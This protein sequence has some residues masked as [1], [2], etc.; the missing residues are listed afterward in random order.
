ME[1][2]TQTIAPSQPKTI[3]QLVLEQL[4]ALQV[5][6]AVILDDAFSPDININQ[7]TS[8]V[9]LLRTTETELFARVENVV[10]RGT[11]NI[12]V[13]PNQ[14]DMLI[15]RRILAKANKDVLNHF[16]VPAPREIELDALITCL[17]DLNLKV[18]P[19]WQVDDAPKDADL[20][21]VDYRLQP[22]DEETYGRDASQLINEALENTGHL[23]RA[24]GAVLMSRSEGNPSHPNNAEQEAVAR[25][26]K[27]FVRCNFRYIEK[28]D[29]VDTDRLLFLLHDLLNSMP[30]G[31]DYFQQV[32]AL[33][34]AAKET[35]E[36]VASETCSL[37]PVD[38]RVFATRLAGLPPDA[39]RVADHLLAIFSGLLVSELR[40][41]TKIE[42]T[43]KAFRELLQRPGMMAPEGVHS[44]SLHRIHSKLIYDQSRATIDGPLTFGDILVKALDPSTLYL[45]LTP[46]CDLEPRVLEGGERGP[47]VERVLVI[48][49]TPGPKS[50]PNDETLTSTPLFIDKPDGSA[51]WIRW[52]LRKPSY[53]PWRKLF[54]K[55]N[56]FV[57]WGRLRAAEAEA[58]QQRMAADMLAVGT[59]DVSDGVELRIV[60][61][62]KVGKKNEPCQKLG[63]FGLTEIASA[64]PG[65]LLWALVANC[66]RELC[67]TANNVLTAETFCMLRQY[68]PKA[69]F[70]QKLLQLSVGTHEVD[71]IINLG[72]FV[73]DYKPNKWPG[74]LLPKVEVQASAAIE[75]KA[76][77]ATSTGDDVTK[78]DA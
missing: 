10:A 59:D 17:T 66:Q 72:W 45:L 5:K 35:V 2:T 6:E 28:A 54:G 56:G 51:S 50:L 19:F 20:Y 73:T 52:N 36:R 21:F 57:K 40:N 41:N 11:G 8:L 49:G 23:G 69:Q 61:L 26:G 4:S 34:D 67:S 16:L 27:G 48:P 46:E 74:P 3:K 75:S 1:T 29:L 7:W 25:N 38:F 32:T 13:P 53:I 71:D 37:L 22:E 12:D 18:T 31:R 65:K 77:T 43:L 33:R 64:S 78:S 42:T 62:W 58:I 47:K 55:S 70:I 9:E 39:N 60:H 14:A 63:E 76:T 24:P 15:I 68:T 44:H 30:V